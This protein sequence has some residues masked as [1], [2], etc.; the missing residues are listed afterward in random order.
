MTRSATFSRASGSRAANCHATAA[1]DDT[2]MTES[3]PKPI[4]AV[5]EAARPAHS[6]MA[7]SMTLYVI[8]AATSSRIRR[9]RAVR[10][11]SVSGADMWR[12][13]TCRRAADPDVPR[14]ASV[15]P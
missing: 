8:V 6:A 13:T 3:N 2:S 7:A 4:N 1:A 11:A 5:E 14:P 12:V 15:V 9:A 10:R